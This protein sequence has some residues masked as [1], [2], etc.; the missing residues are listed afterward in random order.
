MLLLRCPAVRVLERGRDRLE[1]PQ[2]PPCFGVQQSDGP[3][4]GA[5]GEQVRTSGGV[6]AGWTGPTYIAGWIQRGQATVHASLSIFASHGSLFSAP[7]NRF[8]TFENGGVGP[9]LRL[10]DGATNE[11]NRYSSPNG[12]WHYQE[13]LFVGGSAEHWR[14][15]IQIAEISEAIDHASLQNVSSIF[16]LANGAP[17]DW[18]YGPVYYGNGI[19]SDA[20]RDALYRFKAPVAT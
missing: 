13:Y 16:T 19:P 20:H 9:F 3:Q 14:N 2:R 17:T 10:S 11:D 7:G 1:R 15:R 18:H 12:D 4:G 8:N 6:A 5:A